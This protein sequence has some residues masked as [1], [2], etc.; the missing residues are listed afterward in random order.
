[1]SRPSSAVIRLVSSAGTGH[2]YSTRRRRSRQGRLMVLRFDP[3][4]RKH[5]WYTE[6]K[7]R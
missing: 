3:K 6:K 5:T 1:M 7:E 4:R 2:F